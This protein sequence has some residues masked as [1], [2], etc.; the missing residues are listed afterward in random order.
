MAQQVASGADAAMLR[1]DVQVFQIDTVLAE[2]GRIAV[3]IDGIADGLAV[4]QAHQRPG[5][6]ALREQGALDV[7]GAG[8]HLMGGALVHGKLGDEGM[9]LGRIRRRGGAD[10]DSHGYFLLFGMHILPVNARPCRA[11]RAAT[12]G[13]PLLARRAGGRDSWA[14][15]CPRVWMDTTEDVLYA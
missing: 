10:F 4:Q 14:G 2:P 9:D 11:S 1:R 13:I 8:D 3:E 12:S 15:S 6:R 5:G 7:A